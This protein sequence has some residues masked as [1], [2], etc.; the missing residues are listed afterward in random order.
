[1]IRP[2]WKNMIIGDETIIP[3]LEENFGKQNIIFVPY[4]EEQIIKEK[5]FPL[6]YMFKIRRQCFFVKIDK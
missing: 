4:N 2:E 5:Y 6:Q 1:M 3:H